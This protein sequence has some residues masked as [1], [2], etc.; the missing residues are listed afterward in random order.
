MKQK[1]E[2]GR[3]DLRKGDL[4]MVIAGGNKKKRPNKGK[5]GKI[6]RFVGSDRVVVEGVNLITRH[7]RQTGPNQPGGKIQKE[8]AL[9][10]SNV[11]FYA[12]K[13]KR[14]V[15]LKHKTLE[16]GSRVRGYLNPESKQ[17]EEIVAKEK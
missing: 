11:M 12:E 9:H 7:Q 4:V 10:I 14:P 8:A 5:V 16:N 1:E 15:R 3:T 13:F 6:V 17:F 2:A